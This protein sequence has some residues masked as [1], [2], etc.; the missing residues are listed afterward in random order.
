MLSPYTSSI[1]QSYFNTGKII[2]KE[3]KNIENQMLGQQHTNENER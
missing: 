2:A 1:L 3:R